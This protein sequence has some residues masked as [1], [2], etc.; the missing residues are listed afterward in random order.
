MMRL[1]VWMLIAGTVVFAS[2]NTIAG[3]GQDI[4]KGGQAIRNE[5]QE[6]K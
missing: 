3:T 5:A 4:S 6:G 1:I 2:C